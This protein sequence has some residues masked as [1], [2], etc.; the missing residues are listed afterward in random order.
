MRAARR[1]KYKKPD[2]WTVVVQGVPVCRR[3][4]LPRGVDWKK[5]G[6]GV[7]PD[8][9]IAAC[10]RVHRWDISSLRERMGISGPMPG[11]KP[12]MA[13]RPD[14]KW[15][16]VD[17]SKQTNKEIAKQLGLS[18]SYVSNVR[19]EKGMPSPPPVIFECVVCGDVFESYARS[20]EYCSSI[21]QGRG[22]YYKKCGICPEAFNVSNAVTEFRRTITTARELRGHE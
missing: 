12:G 1:K 6:I 20:P 13:S 17:F 18:Q 11:S 3:D 5:A 4:R 10:F 19:K 2:V 22:N 9:L 7:V 8:S 15:S 16:T 14:Q 21:C